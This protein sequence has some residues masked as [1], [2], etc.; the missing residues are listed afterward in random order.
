MTPPDANERWV[1]RVMAGLGARPVGHSDPSDSGDPTTPAPTSPP[2]VPPSQPRVPDWWNT[3]RPALDELQDDGPQVLVEPDDSAPGDEPEDAEGESA[4][5]D[6][7]NPDDDEDT[8]AGTSAKRSRKRRTRRSPAVPSPAPGGPVQKVP[9]GTKRSAVR[10]RFT[11]ASDDRGMRIIAFNLSAAGVGY[12]VGLVPM[13][14][15]FLPAAEHGAVGIFQLVS[16]A[17][18]GYGAWWVTRFPAVRRI[19]PVPPV[20]RA[21]IIAGAAEIGRRLAPVPVA[22]LN[23]YGTQ[24]G[25]GPNA[26]SLLLTAGGMCGGLY[27]L[28]DRRTRTWH[29]LGRWVVRIPLASALLATALYAPGPVV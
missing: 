20:S 19:L 10:S 29:W 16:S 26:I 15:E 8:P 9:A 13:L 3:E 18:A 22:Y 7:D 6:D 2:S 5:E 24:W 12:G 11:A 27:W 4:D 21:V 28:V 14:E 1:R 23:H 17:A 25:F